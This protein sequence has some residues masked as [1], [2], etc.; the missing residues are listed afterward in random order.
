MS[1]KTKKERHAGHHIWC[2]FFYRPIENC[3]MCEGLWKK[4]PYRDALEAGA[5]AQKY[6]PNAVKRT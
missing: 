6:F 4:Y 2:N 3:K 5:L 1:E